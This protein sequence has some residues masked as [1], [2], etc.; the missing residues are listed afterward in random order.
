MPNCSAITRLNRRLSYAALAGMP[1]LCHRPLTKRWPCGSLHRFPG[2]FR[3]PPMAPLGGKES[4]RWHLW[5]EKNWAARAGKL[6]LALEDVDV[7]VYE[8]LAVAGFRV[9]LLD[10]RR[11]VRRRRRVAAGEAVED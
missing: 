5:V 10:E 7:V 3:F 2:C 1:T 4:T 9:E 8:D 6:A 11:H